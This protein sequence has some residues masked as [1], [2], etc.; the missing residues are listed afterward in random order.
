MCI[1]LYKYVYRYINIHASS[2]YTHFWAEVKF[3]QDLRLGVR[4]VGKHA[5]TYLRLNS[6]IYIYTYIYIYIHNTYI[7]I[8]IYIYMYIQPL[9]L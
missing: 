3:N 7:Y 4:H 8:Y 1:Y 5:K 9:T 2:E 6:G